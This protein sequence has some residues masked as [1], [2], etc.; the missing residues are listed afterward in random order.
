[1][2]MMRSILLVCCALWLMMSCG[3]G[4]GDRLKQLEMLEE[5][6]R[7]DSVMNNDSLAEDLV[8]YFDKHGSPNEQMRARYILGRTY[9]D[10]GELPRALETYLKATDCADTTASDCD[11]KTL[12]RVHA[13]S[14]RVYNLQ[15]QPRSQ[16]TEL[17]KAVHL[18]NK[19]N[20]TL[21]AI[22]CFKN[23]A[24]VY[25]LL[26]IPDSVIFIE[27]AAANMFLKLNNK[28]RYAQILGGAITSL[29]KKGDLSKARQYSD[30]YEKHSGF[31]DE[32]GNIQK[33][34]EIYYYIKG[35]YYLAEDKLD[36][37][38]QMFR[39]LIVMRSLNEQI[40]GCKGLQQ[41]YERKGRSDSIAKYA[42]LG[43]IFNDSAYSL[44]EMQNIQKLK[45][46]YNYNHN[47][48][49]AEQNERKAE[50]AM[51]V[52]IV[53]VC[54]F[55]IIVIVSLF[56]IKNHLKNKE[57][58]LQRY[59]KD[60]DDLERAQIELM[61]ICSEEKLSTSEMFEYKSREI[62]EI[63]KRVTGHKQKATRLKETLEERLNNS[64]VVLRLR[65][66]TESNP[67]KQAS[68]ED[69][70]TLRNLVNVE[71]PHFYTT[72]NTPKYTLSPNE[73]DVT[74][75]LRVHFTPMEIHK[76]TGIS[77]SYISNMR[78][79]LLTKIYGVEG[80]PKDYDQRIMSIR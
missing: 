24:S 49:I 19:G 62:K 42:N 29:V 55:I 32:R 15:I 41:V 6:N 52:V 61:E 45:A 40:A 51:N 59:L 65:K 2:R 50:R 17:F 27:E 33:G 57:Q 5:M 76:L 34:R 71:I 21:M 68:Q 1:M 64:P 78:S 3:E 30:I 56:L 14:A 10:L 38:E 22:E 8:D 20:D 70:K 26:N 37:A 54:V 48:L 39:K 36:S 25:R 7:A 46:S 28:K 35:K 60:L 69:L 58:Q 11:Y 9:F 53:V 18:A 73:Y 13:Q 80:S 31:F 44:S 23:Q 72:L 79:R 12:C 67:Y 74:L 47:K 43:Y 75:L 63:L 66:Q 4:K 16:L 77:T